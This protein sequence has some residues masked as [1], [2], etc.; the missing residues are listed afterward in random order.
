M[1]VQ[2]AL[3]PNKIIDHYNLHKLAHE[4]RVYLEV[5][6]RMTGL[7][8]AGK[9][10]NDRL[11]KHLT[12]YGYALV[13]RTPVLWRHASRKTSITL[14]VDDFGIKYCSRDNTDYLLNALRE[15]YIISIDWKG[16]LYI[17]STLK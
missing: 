5:R 14:C 6:K 4:G 2:L 11:A 15:L 13:P 3:I 10:T 9:V 7:K 1:R 8:Q 12:A 16:E 17:G